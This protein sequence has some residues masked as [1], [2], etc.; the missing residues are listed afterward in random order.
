M[1]NI[2]VIGYGTVGSTLINGL[3]K[4][5]ESKFFVYDINHDKLKT[6][7]NSRIRICNDIKKLTELSDII[8]ICVPTPSKNNGAIDL[9]ILDS[10]IKEVASVSGLKTVVIKSTIVPGTTEKYQQQYKD[11]KFAYNPEFLT[12]KEALRDFLKPDRIVIGTNEDSI[13]ERLY[14]L[15]EKLDCPIIKTNPTTA[16]MIKY[17]SNSFLTTKASFANQIHLI[18]KKLGIDSKEVMKTVVL[19]RRIHPSHTKPGKSWNGKCL[20][21]DLQAI[22]K[23]GEELECDVSLLKAVWE[24]NQKVIENE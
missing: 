6:I 14:K 8:F 13:F 2:G 24:I 9:S 21:K 7:E 18:C 12:E 17:A 16:E 3:M 11:K 15:Y 20:P 23:K 10:S 19:D 22:I 4:L 1:A 5:S